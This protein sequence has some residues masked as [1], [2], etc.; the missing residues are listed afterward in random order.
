MLAQSLESIFMKASKVD[1]TQRA[2]MQIIKRGKKEK[3]NL[4][5]RNGRSILCHCFEEGA[6]QGTKAL[7]LGSELV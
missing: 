6:F 1:N 4:R 7:L 2:A 3:K 5:E